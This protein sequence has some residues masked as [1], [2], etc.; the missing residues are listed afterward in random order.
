VICERPKA[1]HR[2]EGRHGTGLSSKG[3]RTIKTREESK[4]TG[5]KG[6]TARGL[7]AKAHEQIK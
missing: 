5:K 7:A 6:G 3:T 1:A 4:H 2:Q